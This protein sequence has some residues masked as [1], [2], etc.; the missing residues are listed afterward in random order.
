MLRSSPRSN[1]GGSMRATVESPVSQ[2]LVVERATGADRVAM[3]EMYLSFDPK[4]LALGL[5]PR[6][7]PAPWLESLS[8]FPNFVVKVQGRVVGHGV[9]CVDKDA[10]ETAVFVHQ[11]WRGHGIGK[12]LLRELIAEGRRQNL[13]RVWGMAAPDNF[14]MLRL[15]DSLG[16]VPGSDPG[17][18]HLDLQ[19]EL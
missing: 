6:K 16:F 1:L 4:G 12:L 15:A 13:R 17:I 11:D 14:V 7:D 2:T 9:L 18:F 10:A 19:G 5:P 3:V 8:A